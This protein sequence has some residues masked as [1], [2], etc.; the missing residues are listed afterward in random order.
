MSYSFSYFAADVRSSCNLCMSSL[1]CIVL[2]MILKSFIYTR[3]R[4]MPLTAKA[5]PWGTPHVMWYFS[6]C[7]PWIMMP[8]IMILWSLESSLLYYIYN[9]ECYCC[10]LASSWINV[11]NWVS[12]ESQA[13]QGTGPGFVTIFCYSSTDNSITSPRFLCRPT[14]LYIFARA[15]ERQSAIYTEH[16][17]FASPALGWHISTFR[18]FRILL[19]IRNP[20]I[21]RFTN[22]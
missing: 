20:Y 2:Y 19:T 14:T 9:F 3:N 15:V 7:T 11:N 12:H 13:S 10:F 1:L 22:H 18:G 16:S 5:V 6:D 8:S 21:N 17:W 4:I